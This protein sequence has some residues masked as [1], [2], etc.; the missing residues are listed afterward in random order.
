LVEA[1]LALRK[2][3]RGFCESQFIESLILLQ[4]VGGE[5]PEDL[6]LLQEDSCLARGLGYELPS[7]TAGREFLER[8]HDQELE[9]L[10]PQR[11][12]QKSFIFPS[13][14]PVSALQ[15]VQSGLVRRVA[16]LYEKTGQGLRIATV[17][18]DA[19]IIE[20]HKSA[21]YY[22]YQEGRGYQPMVALWAEADLVLADEFRDGNVPA[23]Q[24]PL[25]CAKLAF[26][27]LPETIKE[28]YFRGDSACHEKELLDWLKHPD[29]A[30]EPGGVIGFAVSAVMSQ[31]L[32]AA[33]RK[34]KESGW[35]T[36]GKDDDGTLRQW[37]EVDFVPAEK[38][39]RK[40]SQPLRY[41]GLRLLKP[42]GELFKDGTDRH[43]HAVITNREIDGGRLLDWHREK[44][45]TI[46]HTHDEV[47]NELGGGRLPS[48]RF[49]V[50]SAWF[51]L[52][53][54]TYNIVS[55]IKGLCLEGQ[56]RTARMKRFRLLLIHVAGRMNRNNCVMGLRLCN[57]AVA[58]K[59][60]QRVWEVFELPTQATSFKPVGGRG[61]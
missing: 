4:S 48:Q 30:K 61:G 10:R 25:G 56:E 20:S 2:R 41:V 59:R 50:N 17:D 54:L 15:E 55:A 42:Q 40:D 58:L 18:Q 6:R 11:Q 5:C 29:R 34:V 1:N 7:V 24:D 47:K 36:F 60:M 13:S 26:A 35:Q 23:K 52:S 53:L 21:A 51:K 16:K 22:H 32:A 8:F 3:Q 28:R 57:D 39:E 49:G 38:Y 43:F 27:A 19:T 45:G 9:K 44:A 31:D 46:E 12:V 37:A 14:K 33:L